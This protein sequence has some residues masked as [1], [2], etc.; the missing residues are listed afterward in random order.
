MRRAAIIV[1]LRGIVQYPDGSAVVQSEEVAGRFYT[2][3]DQCT[4]PAHARWG[5]Y[6]KHQLAV[7]LLRA[8]ER[9]A[10]R[11][12]AASERPVR[13]APAAAPAAQH[14]DLPQAAASAANAESCF[15]A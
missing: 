10:A 6:C 8:S 14:L 15:A 7:G 13:P 3:T 1:T 5:D 12:R 9:L 2:V 4:C 11:R